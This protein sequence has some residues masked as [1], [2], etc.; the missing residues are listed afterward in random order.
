V[1]PANFIAA[2]ERQEPIWCD[3][4]SIISDLVVVVVAGDFLPFAHVA[5]APDALDFSKPGVIVRL[6]PTVRREGVISFVPEGRAV[7]AR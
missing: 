4:S 7:C 3:E 5:D 2:W 1:S 6:V